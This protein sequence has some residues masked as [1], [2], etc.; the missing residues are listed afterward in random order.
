MISIQA[1]YDVYMRIVIDIIN[2]WRTLMERHREIRKT[3]L[4]ELKKFQM[5]K[6][7]NVSDNLIEQ[8]ANHLASNLDSDINKFDNKDSEISTE[9]N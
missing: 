2:H 8:L 5:M 9:V 7:L 4:R 3:L 6:Q 1:K